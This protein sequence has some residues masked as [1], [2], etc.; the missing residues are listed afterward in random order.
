MPCW[1]SCLFHQK[2]LIPSAYSTLNKYLSH[3]VTFLSHVDTLRNEKRPLVFFLHCI[4]LFPIQFFKF[5][6]T[7]LNLFIYG[8]KMINTK[9]KIFIVLMTEDIS[10]YYVFS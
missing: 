9:E 1:K 8:N 6:K 10:Y 3:V 4:H 5:V 2:G 7:N